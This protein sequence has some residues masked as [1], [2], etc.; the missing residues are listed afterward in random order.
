[1]NASSAAEFDPTGVNVMS[2]R[3][4]T[5]GII[6]NVIDGVVGAE[7]KYCS[8]VR[9][10]VDFEMS[11]GGSPARTAWW[12][13]PCHR[14]DIPLSY[15]R[16]QPNEALGALYMGLGLH[17]LGDPDDATV[18]DKRIYIDTFVPRN[19]SAKIFDFSQRVFP[20]MLPTAIH[21]RLQYNS[22]LPL[23][24]HGEHTAEA[25]I[26][27]VRYNLRNKFAQLEE[28]RTDLAND[29]DKIQKDLSE[30]MR[31]KKVET[32]TESDPEDDSE[33]DSSSHGSGDEDDEDV[34]KQTSSS[35]RRKVYD[36]L[37]TKRDTKQQ[38]V[39]TDGIT[40]TPSRGIKF[41]RIQ[42]FKGDEQPH[43]AELFGS[44]GSFDYYGSSVA[45]RLPHPTAPTF[46]SGA[47]LDHLNKL[48]PPSVDV[49]GDTIMTR[50]M[51]DTDAALASEYEKVH[52]AAAEFRS[53]IDKLVMDIKLSFQFEIVFVSS[54]GNVYV[55]K[56]QDL[57]DIQQLAIS[58]MFLERINKPAAADAG[59][60][61]DEGNENGEEGEESEDDDD[62]EYNEDEGEEEE[63]EEED[64]D[65]SDASEDDDDDSDA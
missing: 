35:K 57:T 27:T 29:C 14:D 2:L 30:L 3:Q 52:K 7:S 49:E 12:T 20:N 22:R 42:S 51:L 6:A 44:L 25:E 54:S 1:M 34:R 23:S 16:L 39:L 18:R 65:D 64:D 53:S 61:S 17:K 48:V 31:D 24:Q 37:G 5:K 59:E 56:V 32:T 15:S 43:I 9:A 11:N 26:A 62:D 60:D 38:L 50:K 36:E 47:E 8:L 21:F 13:V 19:F 28:M 46:S 10:I 55:R 41:I 33:E 58:Q 40:L 4:Q 63:E 45:K